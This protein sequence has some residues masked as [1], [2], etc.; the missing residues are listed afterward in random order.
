MVIWITLLPSK[1]GEGRDDADETWL[2]YRLQTL[3]CFPQPQESMRMAEENNSPPPASVVFPGTANAGW[4]YCYGLVA[5]GTSS[6]DFSC[7]GT[8]HL[9]LLERVL[10]IA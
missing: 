5:S 9:P 7:N 2:R 6:S 1:W 8:L 4:T 10:R 3:A